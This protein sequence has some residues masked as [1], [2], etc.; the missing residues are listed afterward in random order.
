MFKRITYKDVLYEWLE[1]K[2][3]TNKEST[4]L[5]YLS[6]ID[7]HIINTLDNIN[8][9]KLKPSDIISFFAS[10]KSDFAAPLC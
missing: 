5:K 6:I 8:F 4:Y 10:A 9:K 3:K 7:T 1:N 2:R